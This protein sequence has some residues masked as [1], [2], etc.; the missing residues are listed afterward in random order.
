VLTSCCL[1]WTL[2]P[3]RTSA[4]PHYAPPM[5]VDPPAA[6][7]PLEGGPTTRLR[8][9]LPPGPDVGVQEFVE[10]LQLGSAEPPRA[11][12]YVVLNMIST[13]D[14]RATIA[15]RSGP[16]GNAADRE[17]F[18]ALRAA[19]DAVLVGAGT[20]RAERYGRMIKDPA[21]RRRRAE[22]GLAQEPLA[23]IASASLRL[24]PDLPLLA[25]PDARVAILTPSGERLPPTVAS[26]DYVRAGHDGVLD[27]ASALAQLGER[28][29]V[30]TLLCEGG[31][32][33]NETLL[34]AGVVDELFLSLAPK[35]AGG[36]GSE[37]PALRIL[38]GA[39]L[40]PPVELRV[41]SA[42]EC[43]SALF[44]RY[45]VRASDPVD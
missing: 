12:P 31:P 11:R 34:L 21:A 16:I 1:L 6:S 3:D 10:G 4:D 45:G 35:L 44:L 5:S 18:H 15:G 2:V 42:L 27:A 24:A 38:A 20:A 7:A 29:D 36:D 19:V 14:G 22:R 9:L 13:A 25:D 8:A 23:C 32:H 41:L 26:V 40:D 17:L 30:R 33:L 28:H 43:E 37:P 39:Q